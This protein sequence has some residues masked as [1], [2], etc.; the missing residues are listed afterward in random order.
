[1]TLQD[2]QS[3]YMTSCS[4]ISI[5]LSIFPVSL[6]IFHY[7][8]TMRIRYLQLVF[9]IQLSDIFV[10][11]GAVIGVQR[12]F[13]FGCVWQYILT[14]VFPLYACFLS[15]IIMRE[16]YYTCQA[17]KIK[18]FE[19][20]VSLVTA[21]GLPWIVTFL[22]LSTER[23]GVIAVDQDDD[24]DG[25]LG[26]CFLIPGR[27]T[28]SWLFTFWI[29]FAFY[30]WI[31]ISFLYMIALCLL[32]YFH[33]KD[34]KS[35]ALRA[36]SRTSLY[37][38]L[39]YPVMIGAGWVVAAYFD[40]ILAFNPGRPLQESQDVIFFDYGFPLLIGT[41]TTVAFVYTNPEV[42]KKWSLNVFIYF[43]LLSR[44]KVEERQ[45]DYSFDHTTVPVDLRNDSE[46]SMFTRETELSSQPHSNSLG[47]EENASQ[48][49]KDV[50]SDV[51]EADQEVVKNPIIG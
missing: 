1:M 48:V 47:T 14:N 34:M 37:K 31:W 45:T 22:P 42:V 33:I 19:Y 20:N 26:W 28:P 35:K 39:C 17:K 27:G 30:A 8:T 21:M 41:F 49:W 12:S 38:L 50:G 51:E 6:C 3:L 43:G 32:L 40:S 24:G 9:L 29:F 44:E 23:V 10:N 5:V 46:H 36:H 4:S 15:M 18:D 16:L 25:G 11:L 2:Q 7:K 13:T